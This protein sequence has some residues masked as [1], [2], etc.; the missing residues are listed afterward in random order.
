MKEKVPV[1]TAEQIAQ[2]D[3]AATAQGKGTITALARARSGE[4]EDAAEEAD[5]KPHK[6]Y[7]RKDGKCACGAVQKNRKTR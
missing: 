1:I 2:G 7:Y 4:A 6:H 3:A 5:P